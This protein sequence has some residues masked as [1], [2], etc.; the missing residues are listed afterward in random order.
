MILLLFSDKQ[1]KTR[2]LRLDKG[3]RGHHFL[4]EPPRASGFH[5]VIP[6]GLGWR[7]RSG[8]SRVGRLSK[9]NCKTP[10]SQAPCAP[11]SLSTRV[12]G[13]GDVFRMEALTRSFIVS[14]PDAFVLQDQGQYAART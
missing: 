7:D 8:F 1:E 2:K 13:P 9:R 4:D 10:A 6:G 11:P 14:F 5:P 3:R 12:V